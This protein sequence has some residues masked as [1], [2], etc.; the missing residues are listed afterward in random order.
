MLIPTGPFTEWMH[1]FAF[2]GERAEP[3]LHYRTGVFLC[4]KAFCQA[5]SDDHDQS[6][7]K[8]GLMWRANKFSVTFLLMGTSATDRRS[9]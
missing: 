4:Q 3:F 1:P 6:P 9:R 7:M 2:D 8:A 5:F